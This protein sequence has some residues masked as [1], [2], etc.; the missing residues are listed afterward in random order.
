MPNSPSNT[1]TLTVNGAA[2]TFTK[3]A[4]E[5]FPEAHGFLSALIARGRVSPANAAY[6]VKL[7][8][9][10][11]RQGRLNIPEALIQRVEKTAANAYWRWCGETYAAR[12]RPVLA[13]L[14]NDDVL[15]GHRWLRRGSL[16][17]A[18]EGKIIQWRMLPVPT[19]PGESPQPQRTIAEEPC[20]V[21]TLHVPRKATTPVH[22]DPCP[23][24]A[25]VKLTL[26]QVEVI[27][28]AFENAWGH[29]NLAA[30]P[31]EC[32]LFGTPPIDSKV[33]TQLASTA[34]IVAVVP[35]GALAAALEQLGASVSRES[36]AFADRVQAVDT[37]VVVIDFRAV[38]PDQIDAVFL[39]VR[40]A[41]FKWHD[42]HPPEIAAPLV[43]LPTNNLPLP[44]EAQTVYSTPVVAV[45]TELPIAP[46]PL[47]S[48]DEFVAG[49][50]GEPPVASPIDT[51]PAPAPVA[52][53]TEFTDWAAIN[54]AVQTRLVHCSVHKQ[55]HSVQTGQV[56]C[57]PGAWIEIPR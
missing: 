46:P 16:V 51:P 53:G 17:P 27:A 28:T 22:T 40:A 29:R 11:R 2:Y 47:P 32:F 21:W 24:C 1:V 3:R 45:T 55:G 8:A 56:E 15:A 19:K 50:L 41:A 5:G 54:A 39:A 25:C 49:I 42:A 31:A 7:V 35:D 38:K 20:S 44:G 18:S 33:E 13:A 14:K 10:F 36:L 34:R 37:A 43:P 9:R 12:V 52:P 23:D 4:L 48:L 6:Y 26:E 57:G 30:V